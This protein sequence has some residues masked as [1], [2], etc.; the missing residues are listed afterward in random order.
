[1]RITGHFMSTHSSRDVLR[2]FHE[3]RYDIEPRYLPRLVKMLAFGLPMRPAG[4]A[5]RTFYRGVIERT[6]LGGPPVFILGH[7]RSGTTHVHNV[8]SQDPQ[9]GYLTTFDAFATNNGLLGRGLF[10]G[11]IRRV[12]PLKRPMDDMDVDMDLPQEEEYALSNLTDLSYYKQFSFPKL[13]D[14]YARRH[15]F[16]DGVPQSEIDQ[17]KRS[18]DF[19]LRRTTHIVGPRPLLLKNPPNTAR[20]RHL[21]DLYPD[22]KVIY[23][24]RDPYSVYLSTLRMRERIADQMRFHDVSRDEQ[25]E[26]ILSTYPRLLGRFFEDVPRTQAGNFS[27]LRYEDLAKRPIESIELVYS[28]LGLSGFGQARERFVRYLGTVSE[29]KPAKYDRDDAVRRLVEKRWGATHA[30]HE[31]F[32][33]S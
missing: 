11:I 2:T 15:V 25:S 6:P 28:K 22:A 12:T 19:L 30:M 1:M 24:Y 9:F 33:T 31:R 10:K 23:I 29:F 14:H 17:W 21:L 18:Y 13:S 16:F 3:A 20:L 4:V 26:H 5:E 7:W 8:L 32:A 27:A